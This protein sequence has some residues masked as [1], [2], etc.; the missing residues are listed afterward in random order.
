MLLCTLVKKANQWPFPLLIFTKTS[1]LK[2]DSKKEW[3]LVMQPTTKFYKIWSA[4]TNVVITTYQL[5]SNAFQRTSMHARRKDNENENNK[6][7]PSAWQEAV[8][9]VRTLSDIFI[10]DF[11]IKAACA[12]RKMNRWLLLPENTWTV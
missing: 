6:E 4:Q 12:L 10:R 5:R 1:W 11:L 9:T 2:T 3:F 8:I 7:V